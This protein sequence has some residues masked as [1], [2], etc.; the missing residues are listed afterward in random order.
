MTPVDALVAA[1]QAI[2]VGA[3]DNG[4]FILANGRQRSRQVDGTAL[5]AARR[6]AQLLAA[7]T[8]GIADHLNHADE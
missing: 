1:G 6:Y 7:A 4:L 3:K 2:A 8:G 5:V